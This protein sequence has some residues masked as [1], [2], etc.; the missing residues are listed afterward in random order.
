[1]DRK[2]PISNA[3]MLILHM[4][5]N[6]DI[7]SWN[8]TLTSADWLCSVSVLHMSPSS[9]F[10]SSLTRLASSVSILSS[11]PS[12]YARITCF[13]IE[14]NRWVS[15]V[16]TS[17]LPK[18]WIIFYTIALGG[19]MSIILKYPLSSDKSCFASSVSE[20]YAT[21]LSYNCSC[22]IIKAY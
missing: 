19:S 4:D 20:I 16:S 3:C 10:V 9:K 15:S 2:P 7:K 12:G 13:R 17:T 14:I 22:P 1:M 5:S 8:S 6:S 21:T 11:R 18:L